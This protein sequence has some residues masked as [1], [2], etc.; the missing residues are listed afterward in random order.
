MASLSRLCNFA[1]D[2]FTTFA[3]IFQFDSSLPGELPADEITS[4]G[5]S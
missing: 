5:M 3:A 2:N 1:S 4:R